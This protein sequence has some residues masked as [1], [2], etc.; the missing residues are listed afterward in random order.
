MV[1]AVRAD[2][3]RYPRRRIGARAPAR[4]TRDPDPDPDP[5]LIPSDLGDAT[6]ACGI[7]TPRQG[8]LYGANQG[9]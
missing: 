3:A 9:T 1:F 5:V 6:G 8:V 2:S 7:Q 4:R